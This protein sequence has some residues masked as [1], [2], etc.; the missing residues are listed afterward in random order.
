MLRVMLHVFISLCQCSLYCGAVEAVDRREG[1]LGDRLRYSKNFA[2]SIMRAQETFRRGFYGRDLALDI[3]VSAH[4]ISS[5]VLSSEIIT[6]GV[7]THH[8]SSDYHNGC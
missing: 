3:S 6:T 4:I 2:G 8:I 5:M 1:V 7:R